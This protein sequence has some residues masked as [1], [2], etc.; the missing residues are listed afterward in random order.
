VTV[1]QQIKR[2]PADNRSVFEPKEFLRLTYSKSLAS[3]ARLMMNG[4]PIVLPE[5]PLNPRRS[6]IEFEINKDNVTRIWEEGRIVPATVETPANTNVAPVTPP[7]AAT[8]TTAPSRPPRNAEAHSCDDASADK[9]SDSKAHNSAGGNAR[10][11][12]RH[13]NLVKRECAL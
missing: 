11:S 2:F 10:A 8:P 9:S 12:T 7:P 6:T 1:T 3:S 4:K 13:R 5:A